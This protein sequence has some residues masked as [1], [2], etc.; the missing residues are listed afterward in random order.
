MKWT[1]QAKISW[2]LSIKNINRKP[3]PSQPLPP[4]QC[5]LIRN[6]PSHLLATLNMDLRSHIRHPLP[7]PPAPTDIR[8]RASIEEPRDRLPLRPHP[9]LRVLASRTLIFGEGG[10]SST[11]GTVHLDRADLFPLV[12]EVLVEQVFSWAPATDE[13]HGFREARVF[14]CHGLGYRDLGGALLD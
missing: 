5:L 13:E 12:K 1:W 7:Q 10:R 8:P 4:L 2:A 6:L 3:L 11:K 14:F 9:V